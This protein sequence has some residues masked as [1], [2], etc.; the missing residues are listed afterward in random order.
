MRD[1]LFVEVLLYCGFIVC[2]VKLGIE[3]LFTKVLPV[4]LTLR[5]T[6]FDGCEVHVHLIGEVLFP[7]CLLSSVWYV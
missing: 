1:T 5:T 7:Q 2:A 4:G 6:D 3:K